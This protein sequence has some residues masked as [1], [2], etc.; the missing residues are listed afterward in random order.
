MNAFARLSALFAFLVPGCAWADGGT[1]CAT[2]QQLF[3][4]ASYSGD[5]STSTNFVGAFGGLPSPGPDLAFKFTA[6]TGSGP[7]AVTITGGWNAGAVI[8]ASCGG[9]AGNPIQAATGTT[10]FNVPTFGLTAGTLYYFYMTGNPSDN[11]G[12]SGVFNI[13][14]PPTPVALQSFWVE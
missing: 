2:A 3:P 8:T 7:I 11:S 4:N 12:P 14:I 6:V 9:N 1:S 13:S 5:T 10:S